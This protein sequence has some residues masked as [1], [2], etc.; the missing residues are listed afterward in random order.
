MF[1]FRSLFGGDLDADEIL[2]IFRETIA[3]ELGDLDLQADRDDPF[4]FQLTRPGAESPTLSV[5]THNIVHEI[6]G[7]HYGRAEAGHRIAQFAGMIAAALAPRQID[8]GALYLALRHHDY[9]A[10]SGAALLA[11]D[12]PGDLRLVAAEDQGAYVALPSALSLEEAGIELSAA[13]DLSL[14]NLGG[15]LQ[16]LAEYEEGNG[17]TALVI[18]DYAW[19]SSSLLLVPALLRKAAVHLGYEEILIAVPALD[20]LHVVD[21][22]RPDAAEVLAALMRDSF[23]E[24]RKHSDCVFY[25]RTDAAEHDRVRVSHVMQDGRLVAAN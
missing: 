4:A 1:A 13:Y 16:R 2:R 15:V 24:T 5:N 12:G 20:A 11:E 6:L 9:V 7:N 10:Q 8:P 19:L 17:V 21:A 22:G 3:H 23:R 14:E 25:L 18:E